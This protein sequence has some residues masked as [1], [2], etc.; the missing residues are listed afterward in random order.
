MRDVVGDVGEDMLG[1]IHA[2]QELIIR[3]HIN[4]GL[5]LR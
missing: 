3:Q 5:P 2:I 1:G 4:D